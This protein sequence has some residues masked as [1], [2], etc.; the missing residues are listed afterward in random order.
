M[1][2]LSIGSLGTG[3]YE[4]SLERGLEYPVDFIGADAG[5]TDGGPVFLAG[6]RA[7]FGYSAYYRDLRLLLRAARRAGV[8]LLV[9]SCATSG[10]N[11]GVDYFAEMAREGG[12]GGR[13][14]EFTLAKIYS[15]IDPEVIVEHIE[16]RRDAARAGSCPTTPRR[17]GAA[18]ASSACSGPSPSRR[19]CGRAPTWC[20]PAGRPTPPSS[21]P[22]P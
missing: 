16:G 20:W 22:S 11:W 2:F 15:E 19:R 3:F 12:Q 8:P 10:S 9:G 18:P 17:P 4:A 6:E 7:S 5:S 1:S 14:R 13:P 21:P